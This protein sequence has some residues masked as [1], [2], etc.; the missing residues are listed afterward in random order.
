MIWIILAWLA[1][2][3]LHSFLASHRLKHYIAH[4]FPKCAPYYRLIYNALAIGLLIP[5]AYLILVTPS[6]RFIV[7]PSEL[8]ILKTAIN[9]GAITVFVWSLRYYD[10]GEF[11]GIKALANK[12]HDYVAGFVISP[13]HRYVRHPWYSCVLFAIWSRD[14]N[15]VQFVTT[16]AITIYLVMGSILEERKLVIELGERYQRYRQHVP[17]LIP[18]PW[19]YLTKAGADQINNLQQKD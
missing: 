7:W 1:Y 3:V 15:N 10:L 2:F 16:V 12:Q 17:A 13:L 18:L 8:W 5:I 11:L 19:K 9:I 6:S 4:V 14:L